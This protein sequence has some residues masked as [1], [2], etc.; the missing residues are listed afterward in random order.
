MYN[1]F[2]K[3]TKE[4]FHPLKIS[5][6]IIAIFL[7][8]SFPQNSF[9]QQSRRSAYNSVYLELLGNGVFYSINYD[10]MFSKS[11]GGR[12]GIMWIT[13]GD[14]SFSVLP[15]MAN[16]LIGKGKHKLELGLGALVVFAFGPAAENEVDSGIRG[17]ATVG[18]RL[19]PPDGG[20]VFR[21]GFT[22]IF[23]AGEEFNLGRPRSQQSATAFAP[24]GGLSIGI[25]F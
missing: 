7:V 11:M 19:Q 20:F 23:F 24:W 21:V 16:Y 2:L 10:R 4:G 15:V 12:I 25:G 18:Y 9:A 8:M 6:V 17:T 14:D 13:D 5:F 1:S 22:P 3:L